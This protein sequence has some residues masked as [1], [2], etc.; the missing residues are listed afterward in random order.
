MKSVFIG[1]A[2]SLIVA[3]LPVPTQGLAQA[4][5]AAAKQVSI[6]VHASRPTV[7]YTPIWNYFGADEPS[8]L[9]APNGKN[10]WGNWPAL[11]A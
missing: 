7:P 5:P 3:V 10:C 11:T 1:V 6:Q 2:V 8:Y 4:Q 9:Y